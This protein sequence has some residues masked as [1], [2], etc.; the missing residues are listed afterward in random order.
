MHPVSP[1]PIHTVSAEVVLDTQAR[2]PSIKTGGGLGG[3]PSQKVRLPAGMQNP[4]LLN[5]CF[6]S[7]FTF[8]LEKQ[9]ME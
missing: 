4:S 6:L 8:P 2:T 1:C 3:R 7:L 9:S 5:N